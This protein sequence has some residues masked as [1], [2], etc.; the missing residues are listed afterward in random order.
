V[1][2]GDP[3]LIATDVQRF[4]KAPASALREVTLRYLEGKP[5]VTLSVIGRKEAP[6]GAPLDRKIVPPR[7]EPAGYQAPLPQV[8]TLG[9]G[10]PLWVF[11]RR[12]LPTVAGSIVIAGGASLQRPNQ[13]GL[14]ELTMAML[15]EGTTSRTAAEIAMAAEILGASLSASC[16]WDGSYLAF[17]CL[18]PDL[19]A[20]LDLAAD[21]L[22]HPTFPQSEWPRIHGQTLAALQAERDS[23]EA[24]A[25]RAFLQALFDTE[26]PYRFPLAGTEE[27]VRAM[28]LDELKAFHARCLVPSQAAVVVAGDVDPGSLAQELD[29]R[30]ASWQGPTLDLPAIPTA[31][32]AAHPR[33]LL[34]DR[35]G[36]PQAVIRAGHRGL[37]RRD[38]AFE[39]ILV[40]NQILGGQFTSRLNA[41]LREERGFTYGVRSSFDCRRGAGP[42]AI[43]ASVQSD[44]L[45]DALNDIHDELAA[46]LTGRPPTQDEL[47]DARRSLIDGQPRH[48]E[49]PSALVNRY[50]NLLIHGLPPDHE[51]GFPDRL[52]RIDRDSLLSAAQARIHPDALV[53]VVVA[54]AGQVLEDL[55]RVEW[56]ELERVQE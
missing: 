14:T 24:R 10:I 2:R 9:G 3:G 48:F 44:R 27:S 34:L 5:R 36:A 11:P 53:V 55:K 32:P 26:H 42:F 12:D 40:F 47:D 31:A 54:D 33:L 16:G 13:A 38:P 17:R 22:I 50:A 28:P 35:P 30:L 1:F 6:R 39:D 45:A 37:A 8:M 23:A 18:K 4:Q 43:G 7:T 41:K 49:T 20:T 25:H 15:D 56:A 51:A 52:R 19:E 46:I 21:L 29:W